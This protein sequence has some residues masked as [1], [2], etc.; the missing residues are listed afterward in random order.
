MG[1]DRSASREAAY[2]SKWS[3][4]IPSSATLFF[5]SSSSPQ[6]GSSPVGAASQPKSERPQSPRSCQPPSGDAS[7]SG[8]ACRPAGDRSGYPTWPPIVGRSQCSCRSSRSPGRPRPRP[9]RWTQ[10]S[11]LGLSLPN[12]G[13]STVSEHMFAR[14]PDGKPL[15]PGATRG[16]GFEP[17]FPGPKPGVLASLDDPRRLSG[18]YQRVK[19]GS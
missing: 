8:P 1:C 11:L 9:T 10:Q 18:P 13:V 6:S 4:E 2:G 19:G 7:C 3:V 14:R 5:R 12:S 15:E 17:P 16:G